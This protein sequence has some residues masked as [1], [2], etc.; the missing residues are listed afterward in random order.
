MT[1]TRTKNEISLMY[2]FFC[3][4]VVMTNLIMS[5]LPEISGHSFIYSVIN[6]IRILIACGVHGFAFIGGYRL[7][8]ENSTVSVKNFFLKIKR[9]IFPFI[10]AVIV[11]W[12]FLTVLGEA[13]IKPDA[14]LKIA[15][16]YHFYIVIIQIQ[17]MLLSAFAGK[18]MN[19]V[20][21]YV[22]IT[23]ALVVSLLSVTLLPARI[24]KLIFSSYL[25]CYV[26]GFYTGKKYNSVCNIIKSDFAKIVF[27]YVVSL[28]IT[29]SLSIIYAFSSNVPEVVIKQI[30]T[31]IYNPVAVIFIMSVCIR[32]ADKD[33]C[34]SPLFKAYRRSG[35]YVFLWHMLPIAISGIVLIDSEEVSEL[36]SFVIK[37]VAT[38][39]IIA[40]VL[41]IAHIKERKS[42]GTV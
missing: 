19:R 1:N 23:L 29:E 40:V 22:A 6:T 20:N 17:F 18:L 36:G 31:G 7:G 24:H 21:M 15:T 25:V 3:A 34:I 39:F 10:I 11:F 9:I 41:C 32:T 4:F 27:F 8:M 33:F 42:N 38:I 26:T 16:G 14:L 2:I 30:A 13:E 35:Y 37:T 12:M 28:I 5:T